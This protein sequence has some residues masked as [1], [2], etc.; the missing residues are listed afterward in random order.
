MDIQEY[1]SATYTWAQ[2]AP[3]FWLVGIACLILMADCFLPCVPKRAYALVAAIAAIVVGCFVKGTGDAAAIFGL[4]A[5]LGTGLSLLL[6]FDYTKVTAD[7]IA[8][9]SNEEGSSEFYALPLIACAGILALTQARDLIMLFVSL[10]TITLSSYVL[11][12]YF[13]RNQGSIEAGV[14]YLILG[15]MSTGLLVFGAAWYFGTTGTFLLEPFAIDRALSGT[16][17]GTL[18][19]RACFSVSLAFLLIGAFFKV[20]AAPMHIWIPDVYQGAPTPTSTF[21][22]VASKTAG[23][24]LLCALL[25]P[26]NAFVNPANPQ[27]EVVHL[28]VVVLAVVTAATLLIGNLGAINQG[29]AKRLLGYSSI[30]QAG[31]ILVFFLNMGN[32][33]LQISNV[34]NYMLAYTLATVAAFAAIAMVRTQRGSEEI[35][36]FR[37]LGKTNPRTAF[38]IT[39]S[40]ASLAGVPLTM[41][42]IVKLQSFFALL[43]ASGNWAGIGWLLPIMILCAATGFYYYFKVLR[44]MYWV[45]PQPTDKPLCVPGVTVAVLTACAIGLIILGTQPLLGYF[46]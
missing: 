5:C 18:G 30:G 24:A 29:N 43:S 13:R 20:G 21:L 27:S 45:K 17:V 32:A 9:G 41:G 7:S 40:F 16:L 35:A 46:D 14:K 12:G 25:V 42:F 37:G 33:H 38:L 8:G 26:F 36:A 2:F 4:I 6:A 39:V 23:F 31:F 22:A 28:L 34:C 11:A 1:I 15:A 19:V 44:A 3:A 10:E